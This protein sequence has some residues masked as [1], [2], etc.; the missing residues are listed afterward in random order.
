M[1]D[2]HGNG[3]EVSKLLISLQYVHS[4]RQIRDYHDFA[5]NMK[6]QPP[7]QAGNSFLDGLKLNLWQLQAGLRL[8]L[9]LLAQDLVY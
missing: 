6:N 4:D 5:G 1:S 8:V 7:L 2:E 9:I 3:H